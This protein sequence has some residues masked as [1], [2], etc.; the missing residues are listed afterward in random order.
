[1]NYSLG[2][3]VRDRSRRNSPFSEHEVWHVIQSVCES[4]KLLADFGLIWEINPFQLFITPEGRLKCEWSHLEINNVHLRYYKKLNAEK[5]MVEEDWG[6]SETEMEWEE[7]TSPEEQ[8]LVKERER[9]SRLNL[10][11]SNAYKFGMLLLYI[12]TL[13]THIVPVHWE[14]LNKIIIQLA[15]RYPPIILEVLQATLNPNPLV[16]WSLEKVRET[17]SG[18][19]NYDY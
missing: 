13:E 17:C 7:F 1:M 9:S 18:Y 2:H 5:E 6:N 12:L 15:R 10:E 14:L 16:R 8:W 4:T 19:F 11:K 3:H